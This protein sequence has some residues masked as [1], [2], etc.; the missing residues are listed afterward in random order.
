MQKP[1]IGGCA[2][3]SGAVLA[4]LVFL[5]IPARRRGWRAMLGMVVLLLALG[6]FSACG[7]GGG[8]STGGGGGGGG[9]TGTTSGNYT[10]TVRG[11]GN[12]AASTAAT[13]TF[14]VTVN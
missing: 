13:T 12:D 1:P 14:T 2:E 5:G 3:G 10:I 4:L 9:S 7:G 6:C 8:G 11:A